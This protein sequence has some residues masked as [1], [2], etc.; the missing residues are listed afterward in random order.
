MKRTYKVR[1]SV[2]IGDSSESQLSN[3]LKLYIPSWSKF[4]REVIKCKLSSIPHNGTTSVCELPRIREFLERRNLKT[5]ELLTLLSEKNPRLSRLLL[6]TVPL[7]DDSPIVLKAHI[8]AVFG[9]NILD[10]EEL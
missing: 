9:V 4:I 7:F 6:D 2:D 1:F 8:L 5:Q 10:L 3:N